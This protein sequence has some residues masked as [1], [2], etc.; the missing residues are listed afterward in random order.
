MSEIDVEAAVKRALE[1]WTPE[2]A[3]ARKQAIDEA[4]TLVA[5]KVGK[6][7]QA[8]FE[9][10]F[11]FVHAD[12]YK[13]KA[14]QGRFGQALAGTHLPKMFAH[15]PALNEWTER[16][17]T[18]RTDDD[19]AAV[20]DAY[21]ANSVPNAGWSFP[22]VLL[23]TRGPERYWPI[24]PSIEK[25][26]L[27]LAPEASRVTTAED[28]IDYV[29]WVR[30]WRERYGVPDHAVDLVLSIISEAPIAEA[31]SGDPP[32]APELPAANELRVELRLLG[33]QI[34]DV[35]IPGA[36]WPERGAVLPPL[37]QAIDTAETG[38]RT[39]IEALGRQLF[40][41]LFGDSELTQHYQSAREAGGPLRLVLRMCPDADGSGPES[42]SVCSIAKYPWEMLVDPAPDRGPLA[43][44]IAVRLVREFESKLDWLA[45]PGPSHPLRIDVGFA[46]PDGFELLNLHAEWRQLLALERQ[47]SES[48]TL[49]LRVHPLLDRA[50][51]TS[52]IHET[53]VFHF[54]GHGEPG[55]LILEGPGRQPQPVSGDTLRAML[56]SPVP[57]LVVLNACFGAVARGAWISVATAFSVRGVPVV[58]AMN[59]KLGDRIALLFS[60]ELHARLAAGVDVEEAVVRARW[61][62]FAERGRSWFVPVV[63]TRTRTSFSL[64]DPTAKCDPVIQAEV[65]RL[66]TRGEVLARQ[67]SVLKRLS[68]RQIEADQRE[69][70]ADAL[71]AEADSDARINLD[72][73]LAD[74]NEIKRLLAEIQHSDNPS[75]ELR[76]VASTL[77]RELVPQLG[78]AASTIPA[79]LSALQAV[80]NRPAKSEPQP[81]VEPPLDDSKPLRFDPAAG[82]DAI[83]AEIL[84]K[85]KLLLDPAIIHRCVLH[86]LAGRHLVLAGPPGTGKSTLAKALAEAFGFAAPVATA[87][88]DWTTFDT[89]GGLAPVSVHD[90][91]GRAH[92][93]YPFTP[94]CVLRAI[95]ANWDSSKPRSWLVIDEMN[96][97]PLDQAFGDLFTALIDQRIHDPRRSGPLPIPKDF[98]LICTTNTADRRLLFE[99]SEALKRRFAFVE[100]PAF[101]GRERG[102]GD[103]STLIAQLA[104]RPALE[105]VE[106]G[107]LDKALLDELEAVVKRVRVLF[108]LGLAQVL[109]VMTFVA[110][111]AHYG[112]TDPGELLATALV[113]NLLPLLEAQPSAQ[114]E[115]LADLLSGRIDQWIDAFV[116]SHSSYRPEPG[117]AR[118]AGELLTQLLDDYQLPNRSN[119][120]WSEQFT[121]PHKADIKEKTPALDSAALLA[122]ALRR[123]AAERHG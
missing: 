89:I 115:A 2:R 34:C 113:D 104:G 30:E 63:W 66:D 122:Q 81:L 70:L 22:T 56:N 44:D 68:A 77:R 18:A 49:A 46:S 73:L 94:G 53:D 65:A 15:L 105:G 85:T 95:E 13:G 50:T 17:W 97:A 100:V 107:K 96:R 121:D 91:Q 10:L 31:G 54:A 40:D 28:Y 101:S 57:S 11:Q 41:A 106:L 20:L 3:Q 78:A 24:L 33:K 114:L 118:I 67:V 69:Q 61:R 60:E 52:F 8:D 64:M 80:L 72:R 43:V 55:A 102:L 39:D 112:A 47:L 37:E 58:V 19:V 87:N 27:R 99:F 1:H 29:R 110:V 16:L 21:L 45:T 119:V 88:P 51:L 62:V 25:G 98:R 79:L 14:T 83:V 23:Y 123:I 48:N 38:N 12:F 117:R 42:A 108:P 116:D 26:Y 103:R 7:E 120:D 9:R 109:D 74:D 82:V 36:A 6:L 111:G 5:S 71:I 35:R 59:G 76:E 84:T 92:L 86:L 93:S 90:A 32:K 4:R 75:A